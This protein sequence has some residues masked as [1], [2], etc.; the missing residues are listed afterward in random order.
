[1]F[2][3]CNLKIALNSG[4]AKIITCNNNP[5]AN[6]HHKYGLLNS[7]RFKIEALLLTL[8]ECTN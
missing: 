2:N 6:A 1:M 5:A 7:V 3:G 4:I 8:K